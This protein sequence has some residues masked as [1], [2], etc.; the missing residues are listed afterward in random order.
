MSEFWKL[1][2]DMKDVCDRVMVKK[3]NG[4]SFDGGEEGDFHEINY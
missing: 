3:K 1:G 2:M 4:E